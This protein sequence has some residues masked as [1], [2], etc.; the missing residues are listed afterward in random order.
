[1]WGQIISIDVDPDGN[2]Y[3]FQRC[4]LTTCIGR[5]EPPLLKFDVT[6]QFLWSWG[7]GETGW[8]HGMSIDHDGNIWL[9]DGRSDGDMGQQVLKLSPEGDVL[10]R[11]GTP[12]VAG[13]GPYRFNGVSDVVVA[14]NGDIFVADGHVNNRI[15]KY[16]PDGKYIKEWGTKGSGPGEFNMPHTLAL[17]SRGRLFVGD[18]DNYRIQIFDQGGNFIAE[19][20]QFG[21]PSGINI[22]ADDNLYVASQNTDVNPALVRGLY[23]GSAKD[24]TVTTVIPSFNAESIAAD[25][26]R[27]IYSGLRAAEDQPQAFDHALRRFVPE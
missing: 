21:R 13:Y 25:G 1:V 5:S 27:V 3:A 10:M 17:D 23:V 15:V 14:G 20:R 9:T 11:I 18:R 26:S 2:I 12:G 4:A 22:D 16:S 24:G 19:W 6:G 7:S 8:P